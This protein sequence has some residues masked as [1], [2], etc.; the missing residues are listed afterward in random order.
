MISSLNS[1]QSH[2]SRPKTILFLS[3]AAQYGPY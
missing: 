1:N 2:V 3:S